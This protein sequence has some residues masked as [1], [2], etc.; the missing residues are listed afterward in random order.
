MQLTS[1]IQVM[2][3]IHRQ[4]IVMD[5][6]CVNRVIRDTAPSS[7]VSDSERGSIV[8]GIFGEEQ[9][10]ARETKFFSG[11]LPFS[12][13]G[14]WSHKS[15]RRCSDFSCFQR[16]AAL[17]PSRLE[18]AWPPGKLTWGG[19]DRRRSGWISNRRSSR[20]VAREVAG[21]VGWL[22]HINPEP[23]N[24]DA[25]FGVEKDG[26]FVGPVGLS[27]GVKLSRELA[28]PH[29][30]QPEVITQSSNTV[31]PGQTTPTQKGLL[32]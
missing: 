13:H 7:I 16:T 21:E 19:S 23:I 27:I 14:L 32:T 6:I 25:I 30:A 3:I 4:A 8:N 9:I 2:R 26:E 10:S 20:I 31:R 28:H 22:I 29:E 5:D 15:F 18:V 17:G 24:V 12:E 1:S 11:R